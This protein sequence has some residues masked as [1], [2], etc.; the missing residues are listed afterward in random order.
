MQ[1]TLAELETELVRAL[2]EQANLQ[3]VVQEVRERKPEPRRVNV[4]FTQTNSDLNG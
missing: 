4:C 2:I 3:H 1:V